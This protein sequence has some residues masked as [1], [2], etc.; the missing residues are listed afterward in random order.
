M[1]TALIGFTGFV[2]SNLALQNSFSDLFNSKNISNSYKSNYDIVICAA[3]GAVKWLANKEPEKDLAMINNLIE[4]IKPIRTNLFI[5]ISTIDVYKVPVNVNE[6]TLIE[7]D[8]LHAYGKHRYHLESFIMNNFKNSMI[9]RL[10][11]LFGEGIK[12]NLI[13][14]LLNSN[15]S[16]FTHMDSV[17]Q[18]YY[19][20][21]LWKDINIAI[22]NKIKLLNIATEPISTKEI[23]LDCFNIDFK[24]ITPNPPANYNIISKYSKLYG[25]DEN[26]LYSKELVIKDLKEFISLYKTQNK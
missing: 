26:Y 8:G 6:D 11:G 12:K 19:L 22:K 23:V 5:Q 17:F 1:K 4:S 7:L 18:M 25:N 13:F 15:K 3:P 21:N 24:N 10:P 16:E 2:G 20:A 9:I 14:D